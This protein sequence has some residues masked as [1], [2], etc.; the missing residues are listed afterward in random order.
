MSDTGEDGKQ[1]INFTWPVGD[2][3]WDLAHLY[4]CDLV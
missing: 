1:E 3:T 2:T 4:M